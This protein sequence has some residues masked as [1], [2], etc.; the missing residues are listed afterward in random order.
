M[1]E[2][3][4]TKKTTTSKKKEEVKVE[5]RFCTKCGKEL[6]EGEK[7]GCENIVNNNSSSTNVNVSSDA[8]V[9]AAKG[10]LNT[11]NN[12]FRKP[13]TTIVEETN[14]KD[15][16]I[17]IIVL[18]SLAISFAFYLM[19][20]VSSSVKAAADATYGLSNIVTGNIP[21]FKIFIY[22]V[23]IY[24]IMA[25]IPMF[26]AFVIG[27]IT[28]NGSFTFKKAFKLYT[29]SNAPL[30]YTYL[31]MAVVLLINVSLLNILGFIALA[32]I[33]IFCFFNFLL[34]FNRETTIREDR[35]SW[36]LTSIVAVWVV[37]EIIALII[38]FAAVGVDAY[39]KASSSNP[40]ESSNNSS[41]NW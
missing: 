35:R 13:D 14:K 7:C 33:S 17:S 6:K 23:L 26:A 31:G 32:I 12:V 38:I 19:A 5:K 39:N 1:A 4:Q 21:Y 18:V 28:K 30:I 15:N 8:F 10:T 25:V 34:G 20:I 16:T 22:G 2:E 41:F 3:K 40:F 37:I 27:K 11:I 9:N 24:A 29:T 36:A